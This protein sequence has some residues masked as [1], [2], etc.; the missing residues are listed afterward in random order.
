MEVQLIESF[1]LN[2]VGCYN[3]KLIAANQTGKSLTLKGVLKSDNLKEKIQ[4]SAKEH[5]KRTSDALL[6]F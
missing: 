4:K 3:V 5:A 1:W 6:Q 2:M